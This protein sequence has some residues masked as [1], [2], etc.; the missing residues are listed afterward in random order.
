EYSVFHFTVLAAAKNVSHEAFS[1]LKEKIPP[2]VKVQEVL[3]TINNNDSVYKEISISI[4]EI[5]KPVVEH[6]DFKR[7]NAKILSKIIEPLNIVPS[8]KIADSYRSLACLEAPPTSFYGI[9]L[10]MWDQNCYVQ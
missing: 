1:N 6:I 2:W 7:I 8:S 3:Q 5:I 10:F 9:P 4:T